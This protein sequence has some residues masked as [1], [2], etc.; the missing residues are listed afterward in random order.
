MRHLILAV[1]FVLHVLTPDARADRV[2]LVSHSAFNMPFGVD[3]DA[4]GN[5]YVIE[6]GGN[7]LRRIGVDGVVSTVAGTGKK[8]SGG[9]PRRRRAAYSAATG[10][11]SNCRA[12]GPISPAI[13]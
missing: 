10:W 4:T 13:Q 3:R 1:A 2:T 5:L 12:A 7:V 11:A 9:G 6:Y 8:G